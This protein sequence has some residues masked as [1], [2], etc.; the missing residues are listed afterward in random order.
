[1]T[2]AEHDLDALIEQLL[3]SNKLE[4]KQLFNLFDLA[5]EILAKEENV[6]K[7]RAPVTIC[8][9]IHGQFWDLIELFHIGGMPPDTNYLFLGDYVDRGVYSVEV[10]TLLLAFKVRYPARIQLLRGNH[11]SRG[12]TQTYGFY[13]ECKKKYGGN[14]QVWSGFMDAFDF[15]PV[16]ALVEGQIFCQ[17]GGLS[18]QISRLDEI[19]QLDRFQDPPHEGPMCDLL[20]SDPEDRQGWGISPRGAGHTFGEDISHQWL[21]A[22]SI[23]YIARAHQLVVEGYNWMH[24]NRV[25]TIF[26]A[27]N[28]CYRCGNYGAMME[29]DEKVE[30]NITQFMHAPRR[31]GIGVSLQA[32]DYFV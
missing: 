11:E 15:L 19:G 12:L 27:P 2:I 5:K 30:F 9:D 17:H 32:P 6:H 24:A 26:S 25:V 28:Y 13:D 10:A 20:W 16:T 4:E 1:M 14:E 29:V 7:V 21:H 23:Q 3:E 8:G 22:N 31:G 18:P